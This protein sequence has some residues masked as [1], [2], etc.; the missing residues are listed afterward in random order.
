MPAGCQQAAPQTIADGAQADAG[1]NLADTGDLRYGDSGVV[2]LP[3]AGVESSSCKNR[4]TDSFELVESAQVVSQIKLRYLNDLV[5]VTFV[6]DIG[7]LNPNY[8][9]QVKT[10]DSDG[11]IVNEVER[12]I[13]NAAYSDIFYDV[14][15]NDESVVVA[16]MA[17]QP[18]DENKT[19]I[20]ANVYNE[21]L[22]LTEWGLQLSSRPSNAITPYVFRNGPDFIIFWH[23]FRPKVGD[24]SQAPVFG[25]Y[26]NQ[27]AANGDRDDTDSMLTQEHSFYVPRDATRPLAFHREYLAYS[28]GDTQNRGLNY[29]H[30]ETGHSVHVSNRS[31]FYEPRA[32]SMASISGNN[33]IAGQ[34]PSGSVVIVEAGE[35][36][37]SE[38]I[39]FAQSGK[40]ASL[41]NIFATNNSAYIVWFD[42]DRDKRLNGISIREIGEAEDSTNYLELNLPGELQAVS[43]VKILEDSIKILAARIH[44]GLVIIDTI[45]LCLP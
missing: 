2:Y 4:I 10:Y 5:L 27:I 30:I 26:Y 9:I 29:F 33:W 42:T 1:Q 16:Y 31:A 28:S 41:P 20:A 8:V 44:G 6:E 37:Y 11:T 35:N 36:K 40:G 17:V 19:F 34:G 7:S 15:T 22:E 25:I 32:L 23:D 12:A 21:A 3:D 39:Q 45:E 13:W 18:W 14:Q 43:D 38:D 24:A